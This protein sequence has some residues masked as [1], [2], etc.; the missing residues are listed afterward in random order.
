MSKNSVVLALKNKL[1]H[2]EANAAMHIALADAMAIFIPGAQFSKF[3][4]NHKWDGTRHYYKLNS[5]R[6][7]PTGLLRWAVRILKGRGASVRIVDLR[8]KPKALPT[9]T[10]ALR[11]ELRDYQT[12]AIE[13]AIACTRGVIAAATG[14]GKT[15][16]AFGIIHKLHVKT[17]FLVNSVDLLHQT[18][19]RMVDAIPDAVVKIVGDGQVHQYGEGVPWVYVATVQTLSKNPHL[20]KQQFDLKISDEC[21]GV[22]A[23]SWMKVM[24]HYETYYSYGLSGSFD[25]VY[26]DP[27]RYYDIMSCTGAPIVTIPA[28]MMV[29]QG[30]LVRPEITMVQYAADADTGDYLTDYKQAVVGSNTLNNGVVPQLVKRIG[31]GKKVLILVR[32]VKHGTALA[33]ALRKYSVAYVHGSTHSDVRFNAIQDLR[34]GKLDVL[35]A[36]KIFSQGVDIPEIDAIINLG[37]DVSYKQVFQKLG[38]GI[39]T[40]AGKTKLEY[41]DICPIGAPYLSSGAEGRIA[42][43]RYLGFETKEVSNWREL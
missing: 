23:K 1:T 20:I 24:N 33:K 26:E 10:G 7:F 31:K 27:V 16:I 4:R 28:S 3:Y 42:K 22:A 30:Y 39:R 2:V 11:T 12:L 32:L 18:A 40:A 29:E 36:S 38:R 35:I 8:E 21:H 37:C 13:R 15:E 41:Y 34:S 17:L 19:R 25:S 43:Y 14:S 6:A 5:V 9:L